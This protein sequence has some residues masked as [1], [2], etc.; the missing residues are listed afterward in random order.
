MSVHL[1]INLWESELLV[2]GVICSF[3]LKSGRMKDHCLSL[4]VVICSV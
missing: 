3:S 4:D 2:R 1:Q